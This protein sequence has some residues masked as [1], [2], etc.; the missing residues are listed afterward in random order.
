MGCHTVSN[1][2]THRLSLPP[3]SEKIDK[4]ERE[5]GIKDAEQL[6]RDSLP[7][8]SPG[9]SPQ[10]FSKWRIVWRR[11]WERLGHVVQNLQKSWRFLS[12]DILRS[13]EQNGG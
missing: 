2:S 8:S 5:P 12:R 10:R 3:L 1:E 4:G 7:T 11:P 6:L 9:P 13:P